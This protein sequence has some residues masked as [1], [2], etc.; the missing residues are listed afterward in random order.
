MFW[1]IKLLPTQMTQ[2]SLKW[3]LNKTFKKMTF[4]KFLTAPK[5]TNVI[6]FF[7]EGFPY[8][9]FAQVHYREV[10]W[11]FKIESY[12]FLKIWIMGK[13]QESGTW[14]TVYFPQI[15]LQNCHHG[16]ILKEWSTTHRR[17]FCQ[18]TGEIQYPIPKIED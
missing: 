1:G 6:F 14:S 16:D 17:T 15:Y 7:N 12:L 9:A 5:M 4:W 3:I 18:A 13:N 8:P 2:N 11:L 10:L